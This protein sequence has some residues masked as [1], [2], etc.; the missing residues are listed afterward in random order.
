MDLPDELLMQAFGHLQTEATADTPIHCLDMCSSPEIKNVRLTCR[1]FRDTSS[2]LLIRFVPVEMTPVSLE[3]LEQI[4]RHPT[5]SKGVLAVR[6]ILHFYD[7]PLAHDFR[8]FINY[9]G[10]TSRGDKPGT[11]DLG[12]NTERELAI[13]IGTGAT[14]HELW[15]S[16]WD[17]PSEGTELG[18]QALCL[19]QRAYH[20]YQERYEAQQKLCQD[21]GFPQAVATA[22]ARMPTAVGLEMRDGKQFGKQH[23]HDFIEQMK[24]EEKQL[25]EMVYP[26][27]WYESTEQVHHVGHPPLELL[28]QLPLA[29]QLAGT[30]LVTLELRVSSPGSFPLLAQEAQEENLDLVLPMLRHVRSF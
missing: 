5:I 16:L 2:H 28:A 13:A 27:E 8:L 21:G 7:E 12:A 23:H 18:H 24:D 22:M 15:Q 25:E 1:R 10:S 14:M 11:E 20:I 3:R 4:S 19:L 30:S 9:Q 6:V 29:I 26:H 17:D